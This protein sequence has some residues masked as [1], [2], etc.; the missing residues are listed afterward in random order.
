MPTNV[1]TI[2]DDYP[3]VFPS[4]LPHGLPPDRDIHH[5]I[6]KEA[7]AHAK[8]PYL[9]RYSMTEV[10]TI[11]ETVSE[12]MAQGFIEK[13]CSP[14]AAPVLFVKKKDGTLRMV[15]DYRALNAI[16][17]K[18]RYPLPR[19]DD[20]LDK[21]GQ[22]KYFTSLD[23]MSGYHQIR[24]NPTD[25]PKTAFQTP[26]GQY[27]FKVLSFGLC[28]APATFQAVMNGIFSDMLNTS[29]VVY[30]D[31]ILIFSKTE[32]DHIRDVR[33]V[34]DVL[35][36]E[37]F[38]A[39]LSKCAFF[40][41]ETIFLGHLVGQDGIKPDPAKVK[42]VKD[43]PV[44]TNVKEV[45]SFLGLTNYFRKFIQGYAKM[46]HPL[47]QLT[48]ANAMFHWSE[49]CQH[50]F[51]ALKRTLTSAPVLQA[52]DITQPYQV[53][54]DASGIGIGAVLMQGN[55]P[56]AF[57][58]RKL[59][60]A[61]IN[62]STGEQELFAVVHAYT[63]WRC[64]LEGAKSTVITDHH[65]NTYFQSQS[66][67]SRR[68]ARWSEYMQR[69]DYTW[70][71]QPGRTN[72][73]DPLSRSPA[74]LNAVCLAATT[75]SSTTSQPPLGSS[76]LPPPP[77]FPGDMATPCPIGEG[78]TPDVT[79]LRHVQDAYPSDPWFLHTSNTAPLKLEG[80]LWWKDDRLCVPDDPELRT[81]IIADMHD[82]P[83]RGHLGYHKTLQ[84][85]KRSYYWPNMADSVLAFIR[86]CDSCQRV[87]P[88]VGKPPGL[89]QPLPI[90]QEPWVSVSMDFVTGLPKSKGGYDAILV[91]V[92]RL[93]K[94]VRLIPTHTSVTA[95][96]TAQLF[97]D[98][99]FRQHGMPNELVTDRDPRFTGNFFRNLCDLMG[100]KQ[101]LSTAYH[102]QTDGQ[103]ER[104]N[105]TLED[106]LRHFV[107]P[108]GTDWCTYLPSA[109]FAINNA[110]Q[111]SVRNTPFFLNYGRHPRVP[112][113]LDKTC[114]VPQAKEV[115]VNLQRT[116]SAAKAC[117][118][119]ARSRA[120]SQARDGMQ[121]AQKRMK[122]NA[123][124]RR[125]NLS[126]D[127]GDQV[128]LSTRNAGLKTVSSKKL[129]P[130]WIGP[131]KIIGK[132]GEV[133]YRLELPPNL[134]WHN[135]F[136]VALLK[137]YVPGYRVAPPPVP[138][139]ISGEPTYQV[140]AILQHRVR[141]YGARTR[142]EYLVKWEN[143]GP[144]HNSWEPAKNFISPDLLK[145]YHSLHSGG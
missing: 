109:E 35:R 70:E 19:I 40:K 69:F 133:A 16:T 6:P 80:G 58:S 9:P 23:L 138:D 100:V 73:A 111:E 45:R 22:A 36:K 87:K 31:D 21:L 128:L 99:V 2:L 11:R 13:S 127:V 129:L 33:A 64:Y 34:L 59:N 71:Y 52:P 130:R 68:Q 94:M 114:L 66:V 92:D 74:L 1:K 106:M 86:S 37:K 97:L 110:W 14:F 95:K 101:C 103:T 25:V 57:E 141:K 32:K 76:S 30:L 77:P 139:M 135:V 29:V 44:L 93:T 8:V 4:V 89:L 142:K 113:D 123:D 38:Y 48:K 85:V 118:D 28:N 112:G 61:Q 104:M 134:R 105:R 10:S 60:P 62:Y 82:P 18:I 41:Q 116:L 81:Q 125:S 50:A 55:G 26:E 96:Q 39:K 117:L 121:S 7:G 124:E 122:R 53:I 65:P 137:P 98:E 12:L 42:A 63:I 15:I 102:P 126:F 83:Y 108:E 119:A 67:L 49:E 84:A 144:E 78:A 91:V 20:L 143:Y 51:T 88:R 120:L 115:R 90:P 72:V 140:E 3:D 43:W 131:L 47:H 54:C 79:F 17:V 5:V 27:Q 56:I 107:N 136:H 24:I 75:R 46:A 145:Q 132:V